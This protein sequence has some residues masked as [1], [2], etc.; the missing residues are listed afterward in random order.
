MDTVLNTGLYTDRFMSTP[1]KRNDSIR[2]V[3]STAAKMLLLLAC[4][5]SAATTE[6]IRN[7]SRI[8]TILYT[9]TWTTENSAPHIMKL[10]SD[11]TITGITCAAGSIRP[12]KNLPPLLI[13][14]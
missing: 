12:M 5:G 1:P 9:S 6:A 7:A 14:I 8:D 11:I 4:M 3:G 13:L 2:Y 10:I